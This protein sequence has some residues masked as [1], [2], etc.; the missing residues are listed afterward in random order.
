[1]IRLGHFGSAESPAPWRVGPDR[2]K[3]ALLSPISSRDDAEVGWTLGRGSQPETFPANP[4]LLGVLEMS[5][6]VSTNPANVGEWQKLADSRLPF[7]VLVEERAKP[8]ARAVFTDP[9]SP[10]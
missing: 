1:M 5:S 3:V 2:G 10:P 7:R 8:S 6:A 9:E 4:G